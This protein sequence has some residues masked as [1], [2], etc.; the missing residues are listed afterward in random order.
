M[1]VAFDTLAA[2]RDLEKAG[3][4]RAQAEAVANVVRAGQGELAT[5][6]DVDS[7]REATRADLA[8]VR[9]ELSA[10]EARLTWR[11]VIAAGVIVAAVKLIPSP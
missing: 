9:S 6:A 8:A 2:A 7:L 10:L 11:L 4:D 1:T 5:K 3:M